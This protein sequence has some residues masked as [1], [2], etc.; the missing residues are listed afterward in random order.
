MEG[1]NLINSGKP[2]WIFAPIFGWLLLTALSFFFRRNRNP[3]DFLLYIALLLTLLQSIFVVVLLPSEW[4]RQTS[5][6]TT[7]IFVLCIFLTAKTA[8][9]IFGSKPKHDS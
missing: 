6:Y 8:P 2:F 9:V 1:M 7:G 5:P 3:E 4:A